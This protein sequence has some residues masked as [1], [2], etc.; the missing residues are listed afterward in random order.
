MPVKAAIEDRLKHPIIGTLVLSYTAQCYEIILQLMSTTITV[1]DKILLVQ[2][3]SFLDPWKVG[4]SILFTLAWIGLS[5]AGD[6][7]SG[8]VSGLRSK[9]FVNAKLRGSSYQDLKSQAAKSVMYDKVSNTYVY[10]LNR[11]KSSGQKSTNAINELQR[12]RAKLASTVNLDVVNSMPSRIDNVISEIKESYTHA[13]Y[14]KQLLELNNDEQLIV[15]LDRQSEVINF[16]DHQKVTRIPI[17]K[18]I[19]NNLFFKKKK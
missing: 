15:K 5:L 4:I 1:N 16:I 19:K 11:S 10:Y 12:I 7:I 9:H 14:I 18:K 8:Y 13:E 6:S 3:Y 17:I 2:N